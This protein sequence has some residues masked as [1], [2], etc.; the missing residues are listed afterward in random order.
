MSTVRKA[1]LRE[2]RSV[3]GAPFLTRAR[4]PS[5]L[6]FLAVALGPSCWFFPPLLIAFLWYQ[7]AAPTHWNTEGTSFWGVAAEYVVGAMMA[8]AANRVEPLWTVRPRLFWERVKNLV[9]ARWGL[10]KGDFVASLSAGATV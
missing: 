2:R 3:L 6:P 8:A 5:S 1:P 9:W 4:N 10:V 7:L